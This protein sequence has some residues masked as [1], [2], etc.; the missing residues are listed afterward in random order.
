M[1]S[2]PLR[3]SL[4]AFALATLVSNAAQANTFPIFSKDGK[5]ATIFLQGSPSDPDAQ[6]L[7]DLLTVPPQDEQGK[8]TKKVKFTNSDSID[9][10]SVVCAF[11]KL[12]PGNGSCFKLLDQQLRTLSSEFA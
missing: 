8:M 7:F 11:S 12:I 9:A 2:S 3:Y 5:Q 6:R 10:L 4:F 1:S